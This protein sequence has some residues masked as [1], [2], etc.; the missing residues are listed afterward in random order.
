MPL[1]QSVGGH[2]KPGHSPDGREHR[3]EAPLRQQRNGS[4]HKARAV[5]E[6]FYPQAVIQAPTNRAL[7]EVAF[8]IRPV[9]EA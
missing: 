7:R 2:R 1:V 8:D 3:I 4:R 5:S 9:H 6:F